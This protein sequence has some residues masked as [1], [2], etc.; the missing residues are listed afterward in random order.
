MEKQKRKKRNKRSKKKNNKPSHLKE[1]NIE[2]NNKTQSKYHILNMNVQDKLRDMGVDLKKIN[3]IDNPDEIKMSAVILEL[4]DP[5]I[6]MYWGNEIQ[7]RGIISLAVIVWNM[8]FLS[9][10]EQIEVQEKWIEIVLPKDC[11]A[12][13]V[14]TMLSVFDFLQQRQRDL[15]PDIRKIVMGY[16]LRIDNENIHLD[17]SSAPIN[18]NAV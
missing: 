3:F 11:N 7:I 2:N 14:A 4:A 8:A 5:Y 6:K 12:K 15:F 13:D 1:K 18:K 9:Q 10:K 16:E 17:V